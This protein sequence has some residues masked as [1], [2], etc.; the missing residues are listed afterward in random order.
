VVGDVVWDAGNIVVIC[1]FSSITVQLLLIYC[2]VVNGF[3][4]AILLRFAVIRLPGQ[5]KHIK[6]YQPQRLAG[7]IYM[8]LPGPCR[9]SNSLQFSASGA[10]NMGEV[11]NHTSFYFASIASIRASIPLYFRR[12][13]MLSGAR[14]GLA[15]AGSCWQLLGRCWPA[16]PASIADEPSKPSKH[17]R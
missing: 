10:R 1:R 7:Y 14:T 17:C 9:G 13:T 2:T 15:D 6:A 8:S 16:S 4:P 3:S 11:G 5:G 12:C